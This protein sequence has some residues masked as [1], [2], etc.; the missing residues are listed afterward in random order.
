MRR[1]QCEDP[2]LDPLPSSAV[3]STTIKSTTFDVSLH[4]PRI[5]SLP[6]P[7]EIDGNNDQYNSEAAQPF[8]FLNFS[9]E[10]R[11]KVYE[12]LFSGVLLDLSDLYDRLFWHPWHDATR[13]FHNALHTVPD[14]TYGSGN[15]PGILIANKTIRDEAVPIFSVCI[16]AGLRKSKNVHRVPKAHLMH[17]KQPYI[18]HRKLRPSRAERLVLPELQTAHVFLEKE[19]SLGRNEWPLLSSRDKIRIA[20]NVIWHKQNSSEAISAIL[21]RAEN[22]MVDLPLNSMKKSQYATRATNTPTCQI[23]IHLLAPDGPGEIC[24]VRLCM[25]SSEIL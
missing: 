9:A 22:E 24:Y 21:E 23:L 17:T 1:I 2:S 14:Q 6:P 7:L 11:L 12:W 13:C 25:C 15:L 10:L 3:M 20:T 5:W 18:T 8:P 4:R 16:T 19:W